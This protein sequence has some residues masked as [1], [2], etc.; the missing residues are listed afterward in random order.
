MLAPAHGRRLR[1]VGWTTVRPAADLTL[2]ATARTVKGSRWFFTGVAISPWISCRSSHTL[3][4]VAGWFLDH[5]QP[6]LALSFIRYLLRGRFEGAVCLLPYCLLQTAIRMV[7]F[8]HGRDQYHAARWLFLGGR[9]AW[10]IFRR[11]FGALSVVL[12]P[13]AH[14]SS[15]K[16]PCCYRETAAKITHSLTSGG[17]WCHSWRPPGL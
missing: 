15:M 5:S 9:A 1:G 8:W 13:C 16:V 6:W 12:Q 17:I 10:A 2:L 3:I 11:C 4:W 7:G 14:F